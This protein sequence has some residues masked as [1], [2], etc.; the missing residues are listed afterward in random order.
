MRARGILFAAALF[1]T[2]TATLLAQPVAT[3]DPDQLPAIHGRVAQWSLTPRGDI[4]GLILED[5]TQVHMPPHL[6]PRLVDAVRPGDAVTVRGL[7]ARALPL[8]QALSVTDNANGRTV[9][10]DGPGAKPPRPPPP[11][12]GQ[13]TQVDGQI[14][15]LLYGPR[16]DTNGALLEDGT[17]VR[18]PP[19]GAADAQLAPGR[20]LVAQGYRIAGPYGRVLDA[21]MIGEDPS[22]L[23]QVGPPKPRRGD[24][25]PPR[26]R[27]APPG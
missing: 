23:V 20:W 1:A 5:G 27:P 13:W 11:P 7:R 14:R 4:D 16:G 12:G 17:Q 3:Y 26:P 10:D 8:V 15:Q 25:G 21:Q 24:R 19:R 2:P 9:Q 18:V 22:R 6:G